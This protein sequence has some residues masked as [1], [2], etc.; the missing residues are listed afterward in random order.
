[1]LLSNTM[2]LREII[3]RVNLAIWFVNLKITT[4]NQLELFQST[5]SYEDI[6]GKRYYTIH[7]YCSLE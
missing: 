3:N 2:K 1:M 4:K 5:I 6:N 7:E